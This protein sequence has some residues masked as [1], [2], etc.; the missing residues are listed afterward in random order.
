MPQPPPIKI[1]F[2]ITD[3]DPGG[4]ERALVQ[5]VTR[6]DRQRFDPHVICLSPAGDL[7]TTLESAGVPVTCLN[8]RR[9]WDISVVWRLYRELRKLRPQ[10]LQTFLFHANLAGRIAAWFARVP[11]V[12]SGIRVAEQR[13]NSYL[14]LDRATEWMVEKHVCVSQGVCEHS[15]SSGRLSPAKLCVIPNGVDFER[16][17]AAAPL[18]LSS[19]KIE[20]EDQVWVTVGRLDPQKGPWDLLTAVEQLHAKHPRLKLLWAGRGPLQADMQQWIDTHQLQNTI[21]LIGWQDNIPGLLRAARGFVLFSHW[22][23]MPNVVL[24]ALAAGLPVISTNVEGVAE[25]IDDRQTGWIVKAGDDFSDRWDAVLQDTE[26]AAR[27]AL[28]GQQQVRE[29]FSWD[30]MALR[31]MDLYQEISQAAERR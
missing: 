24:E 16:F 2:C 6:L 25:I 22:E 10:I 3:L 27:V 31:Y 21:H 30:A 13:R 20:P 9:R 12:I 8:V 19:W 14:F 28:A 26:N 23:G 1:A 11:H 4:A 17:S 29:H 15:R 18:D 5:L 7:T